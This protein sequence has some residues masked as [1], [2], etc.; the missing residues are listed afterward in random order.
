MTKLSK[1]E[2][3]REGNKIVW[4]ANFQGGNRLPSSPVSSPDGIKNQRNWSPMMVMLKF[5]Q[6]QGLGNLCVHAT[7]PG[8]NINAMHCWAQL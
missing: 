2:E 6:R 7:V 3:V 5:D 8:G 1:G 4:L